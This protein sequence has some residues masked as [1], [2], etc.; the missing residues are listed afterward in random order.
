MGNGRCG[1]WDQRIAE[2]RVLIE[3]KGRC[4]GERE[5][6]GFSAKEARD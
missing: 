2:E 3:D 1:R 6:S 4:W 5:R